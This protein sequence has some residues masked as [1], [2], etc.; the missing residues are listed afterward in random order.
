MLVLATVYMQIALHFK[1][2]KTD[3]I[4]PALEQIFGFYPR[5]VIASLAAYLVSQMHDIWA[6]H[7]WKVKARGRFLWLRNNASTI[8]IMVMTKMIKMTVLGWSMEK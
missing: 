7:F 8:K 2:D 3:F 1:P 5:V 6:Y 4:H